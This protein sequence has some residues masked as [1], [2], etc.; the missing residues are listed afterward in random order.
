MSLESK[1]VET[2]GF[3]S[4]AVSLADYGLSMNPLLANADSCKPTIPIM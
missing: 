2:C 4:T 1:R 3:N